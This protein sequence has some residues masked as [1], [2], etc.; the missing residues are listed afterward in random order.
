MLAAGVGRRLYGEVNEELPKA[1]LQFDGK[2]L[3]H[4]HIEILISCGIEELVLVVGHRSGDLLLEANRVAPPGFISSVYNT[5]YRE[6]PKLSLVRGADEFYSGCTLVFMDADVLYHPNLMR[7]LVV[8]K[9]QNCFAMDRSFQS[10]NDFVKICLLE[11]KIVDFGKNIDRE[12]DTVGEWPGFFKMSPEIAAKIA[13]AVHQSI[14]F[15]QEDGDYEEI[16]REVLFA[17]KPDT[18]GI[19]DVTG[20]PWVEID[21]KSDLEKAK[22]QTLSRINSYRKKNRSNLAE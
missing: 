15:G 12:H 6:G 18:F 9:F 5:R 8:S 3:I 11:N 17:S 16:F 1:L 13:D 22:N 19:E 14:M 10:T 20:I 21:N 4:R 7:Q 2:T